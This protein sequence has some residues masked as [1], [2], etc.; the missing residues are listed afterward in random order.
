MASV[1]LSRRFA[2]KPAKRL[3][4][5]PDRVSTLFVFL[6]RVVGKRQG[7]VQ[8]FNTSACCLASERQ[9]PVNFCRDK[10]YKRQIL[11]VSVCYRT[12]AKIPN[13]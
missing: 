2:V 11:R 6:E 4:W 5:F 8:A 7:R 12:L 3:G 10:F 1:D 9:T 13:H